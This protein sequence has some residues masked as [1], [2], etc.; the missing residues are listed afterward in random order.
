M[1]RQALILAAH[2]S[3][4][5]SAA[6]AHLRRMAARLAESARFGHVSAAFHLGSPGYA[7]A[8]EG[9]DAD[10]V[11][12][13]P[14]MTSEGWYA[15]T[16]LPRELARSR[17]YAA[18]DVRL[19]P[20]VGTHARIPDLA[21]RHIRAEVNRLRLDPRTVTLVLVGHG[22][23]RDPWS[24]VATERLRDALRGR[25]VARRVEAAFLDEAPRVE[26]AAG[27]TRHGAVLFV[28]FLIGGGEHAIRDLPERAGIPRVQGC[29]REG[30]L[31]RE[32]AEAREQVIAC[33]TPLGLSPGLLEI[34]AELAVGEEVPA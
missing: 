22:T 25:C 4:D 1:S 21:A 18:V 28:P 29:G 10:L 30:A 31:R 2:G 8:L 26:D 7:D 16:V 20:P 33:T 13:V 15:R 6:N 9:A 24:R 3:G 32:A 19:T 27:S 23:T 12:V 5:G 17:R 34:I 11:T 14:V